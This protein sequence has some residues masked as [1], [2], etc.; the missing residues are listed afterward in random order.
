MIHD[1][2]GKE[3]RKIMTIFTNRHNPHIGMNAV[4]I[5]D[6]VWHDPIDLCARNRTLRGPFT[7]L[8]IEKKA[9]PHGPFL[10]YPLYCLASGKCF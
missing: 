8:L 10:S 6:E 3:M 5:E 1:I 9:C 7:S 4:D 2:L